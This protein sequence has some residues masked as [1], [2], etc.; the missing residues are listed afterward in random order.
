MIFL[1]ITQSLGFS[2]ETLS[3]KSC[4]KGSIFN[5]NSA[6]LIHSPKFPGDQVKFSL[7]L[8]LFGRVIDPIIEIHLYKLR[9][10][11]IRYRQKLCDLSLMKCPSHFAE[12]VYGTSFT[13]PPNLQHG[14]YRLRVLFLEDHQK[15]GCYESQLIVGNN[16]H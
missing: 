13:I 7:D 1:L 9:T 15:V 4:Q 16:S 8:E 2:N 3:F 5:I 10:P 12:F 11:D 14:K 6:N